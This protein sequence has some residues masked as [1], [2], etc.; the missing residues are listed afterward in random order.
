MTNVK[1]QALAFLRESAAWRDKHD[2]GLSGFD[3]IGQGLTEAADAIEAGG[4]TAMTGERR[5]TTINYV[6]VT[7]SFKG[8]EITNCSTADEVWGAIGRMS[9]GGLYAVSSP[10]GLSV[11]EFIPFWGYRSD[12]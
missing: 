3:K 12:A 2:D 1:Q 7:Y 10:N 8:R 5:G 4:S 9:F 6:V 11:D